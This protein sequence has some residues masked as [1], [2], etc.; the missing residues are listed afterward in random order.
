MFTM[1]R[2]SDAY[3][4][5][6]PN[7]VAGVDLG[8]ARTV[9]YVPMIRDDD[10]VGVINL[11]RREV[12]PFTDQQIV[13]LENFATQAVIAIENTRLLGEL[14]KSLQQQTATADVLKVIS[15]SVFDLQPILETLVELAARLCE[16][17]NAFVY[18]RDASVFRLAA[19]YGFSADYED[20]MKSQPVQPG[21]GTLIGRTTLEASIVHIPDVLADPEY[22]WQASQTRGG[23]R[24]MLGV[25]MLREGFPIGVFAMTR[26]TVKPF[27]NEQIALLQT[28]TDQAAIAIEN[29]RLFEE[30]RARTDDLSESLR[31]QTAIGDVLKTISRSTFDLQPVL[32]TL[33]NTAAR[34]CDADMAFI[35]RREGDMYRAGAAVGF[36]QEY[37]DFLKNNPLRVDRG[38][39]TGRAVL[40]RR[41]VHI[42][43][44][45]TDPEYML[46]ELTSL[47]RQHTALGVPLLRE[48]EPIGVI[49]IARQRVQGFT[50]KQIDLVTTF[51]DQAVIAIENVRLFDQL[52][53]RTDD[54]AEAL[55]QQTA[56]ADVL[57]V[58]SASPGELEAVFQAMLAERRAPL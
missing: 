26:S 40:E 19:T 13:L 42:L 58:I 10:I 23:Y 3:R 53:H 48:N 4:M 30:V 56:T 1:L 55:E 22:S 14:R 5:G 46:R 7:A 18:Q 49:V 28:F 57:K 54:L 39:I 11:Y 43:D 17:D 8:G 12:R 33:V 21:R 47:A 6:N 51:A 2:E 27:T 31:Q 37:I 29:V 15:R 38:T 32:D 25:P 44:V 24:T 35:M 20:F 9:L 45:A 50:Q 41:T 52:R 36:A 16:A 34:L